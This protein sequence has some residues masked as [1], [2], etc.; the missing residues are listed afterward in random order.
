[1]IINRKYQDNIDNRKYFEQDIHD[2]E[3][4]YCRMPT[5]GIHICKITQTLCPNNKTVFNR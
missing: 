3:F 5:Q 2:M 4:S 1:M